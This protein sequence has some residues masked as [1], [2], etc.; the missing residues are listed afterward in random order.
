[1]KS[2]YIYIMTN[3]SHSTLYI[4]ITSNLIKRAY[5]HKNEL[6]DGFTK[7]YKCHKLVW[8]METE[9]VD[10]TIL[11]EKRMKK[12]KREYKENLINQMN[13]EWEDLYDG[14]TG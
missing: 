12:W 1:M 9:N 14:L 6:A 13:P 10:S 5:E 7:K 11:Q 2:Y 4:G 3:K 8:Y